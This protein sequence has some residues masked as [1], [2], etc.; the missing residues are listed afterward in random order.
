M[1]VPMNKKPRDLFICIT[2]FLLTVS[3]A[4]LAFANVGIYPGSV[5]TILTYDMKQQLI[6]LYGYL[7]VGGPGFDSLFYS[8]TGALGGG[9]FGTAALYISP[10]DLVYTFIPLQYLP[11][12]VYVMTI[13]KIGFSAAFLSLFLINSKRNIGNLPVVVIS[14]CYGL[15][16]YDFMYSMSPMWLDLVMFLPLLALLLEKIIEGSESI[17]FI[18][19]MSFCIISDYYISYMVVITIT[20]YFVFRIVET[21]CSV[22]ECISRLFCFAIHGLLSAG[23]SAFILIPVILDFGRGK[24]IESSNGQKSVFIKN[25]VIA[26]LKNFAPM[27]Y[28]SLDDVCPPNIFCGSIVLVFALIWFLAGKKNIKSRITGL[29]ILVIYF[30]SFV[31]GPVDRIWHGF[32]NPIGFSFRYAFTFVFFMICFAARGFERVNEFKTQKNESLIRLVVVVFSIYTFF[33]LF[34][35]GSFIL[36]KHAVEKYYSNSEEYTRYCDVMNGLKSLADNDPAIGYCRICKNFRFSNYDGALFGY[37]GIERFSSSYNYPVSK[38]LSDLGLGSSFHTTSEFGIN[39]VVGSLFD[40]GY[41]LSW[42]KDFSDYYELIGEYRGYEIYR[43]NDCLPLAFCIDLKANGATEFTENKFENINIAFDELGITGEGENVFEKQDYVMTVREPEAYLGNATI[44]SR[45]YVFNCNADG[46]YWFYSEN[47]DIYGSESRAEWKERITEVTDAYADYYINGVK[48]PLFRNVEF[49]FLNDLGYMEGGSANTLTL[50]SSIS[51]IGDTY[52]YRYNEGLF[53][54]VVVDLRN[55]AF[56]VE[57]I[58][59]SGI[60][61]KGMSSADSYVLI[62]LPYEDGYK[63]YVDGVRTDYES[64]RNALMLVEVSAGEHVIEIRY[65]PPGLIAGIVVSLISIFALLMLYIVL[66]K[67]NGSAYNNE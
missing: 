13:L 40:V 11:D 44:A 33:E 49:S 57:S 59:G 60:K 46:H 61:L 26:I 21:G 66:R 53:K 65:L 34:L 31:F 39:P 29:L 7:S 4:V 32:R 19:L 58:D 24:L 9:F 41:I 63:V 64:Y 20:L 36:S 22:R 6:A 38:F 56:D 30:I 2:S 28:G 5:N 15:M 51:E 1:G 42:Y 23:L 37:D 27:K 62:T 45:D 67:K 47:V 35:N 8:M 50:D 54:R 52:I 18:L 3:V 48:T 14:C 10:F 12:A 17:P 16:S 25:S 43:N 55:N